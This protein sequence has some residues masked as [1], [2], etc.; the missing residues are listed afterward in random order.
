MNDESKVWVSFLMG[1]GLIIITAI[2]GGFLY[3]AHENN[4]MADAIKSG[5]DP[6]AVLCVFDNTG[7]PSMLCAE[8][9]K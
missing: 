4:L 2:V 7:V 9:V 1:L 5:A 8:T 3:N 6:I